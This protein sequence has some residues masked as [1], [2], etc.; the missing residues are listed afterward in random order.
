MKN[1]ISKVNPGSRGF[2]LV[3]ILVVMTIIFILAGVA[4]PAGIKVNERARI[5]SAH[6]T[7]VQLATGISSYQTEYRRLPIETGRLGETDVLLE[8]DEVLMGILLGA[9]KNRNNPTR[10]VFF[11]GTKNATGRPPKDG[12]AFNNDGSGRLYDPWGN[13][14][15]VM[16]D[17]D[18]NQRIEPPFRKRQLVGANIVAKD[19]VVWS[20]GPDG[21]ETGD[22]TKDNICTW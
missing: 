1:H 14:Y 4:I 12:L 9:E 11:N 22:G 21:E 18:H 5:K 15:R 20:L 16:M 2:T 7:A 3:E 8:T 6:Q 17:S 10:T 19:I 13:L